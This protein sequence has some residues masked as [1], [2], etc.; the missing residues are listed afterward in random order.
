[1]ASCTPIRV[2]ELGGRKAARV[3]EGVDGHFKLKTDISF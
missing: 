2:P 1:M 3:L